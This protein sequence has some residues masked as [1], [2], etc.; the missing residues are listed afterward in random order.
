MNAGEVVAPS[1][2]GFG[3]CFIMVLFL[4]KRLDGY[5]K[6]NEVMQKLSKVIADGARQFLVTEYKYLAAFV[7]VVAII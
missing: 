7:T 4:Q 6:G 3:L 5:D 1:L 2:V